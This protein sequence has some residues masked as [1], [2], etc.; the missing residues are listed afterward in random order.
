M[1]EVELISKPFGKIKVSD[2]QILTF[3]QGI[4][5]FEDY[6]KYALI[7]EAEDSPFKWLQ[8]LDQPD[9]AFIVI[10][11]ELFFEKYKPVVPATELKEINLDNL[12]SGLLFVI[13]TIPNDKPEDMT[14]NLQGPIVINKKNLTA[15]QFISRDDSH[16]VRA[17]V[18][19]YIESAERA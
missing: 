15:K 18:A 5:G 1:M 3:P 10:Q 7:E 8:S 6:Y 19:D 13:I 9:L 14:V 11:P 17:R 4:L 12:T 16:S 2:K